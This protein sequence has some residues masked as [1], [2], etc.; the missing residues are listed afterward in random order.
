MGQNNFLWSY[1]LKGAVFLI[2]IDNGIFF[3]SLQQWVTGCYN[4]SQKN[5]IVF[6]GDACKNIEWNF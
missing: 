3:V 1:A 6:M 4:D 2:S 5:P